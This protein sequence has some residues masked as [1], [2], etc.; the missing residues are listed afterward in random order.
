MKISQFRIKFFLVGH[1][2]YFRN[3]LGAIGTIRIFA[4]TA[5]EKIA[6][7]KRQL[8]RELSPAVISNLFYKREK[9]GNLHSRQIIGKCFFL[10]A[11]GVE[12]IP[13]AMRLIRK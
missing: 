8:D 7:E 4:S 9:M 11:A 13:V 10:A 2:D 12:N 1:R 5:H 6:T 3:A